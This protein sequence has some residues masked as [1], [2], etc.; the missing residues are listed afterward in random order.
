VLE[1]IGM[2][3]ART[4]FSSIVTNTSAMGITYV[5][6]SRGVPKAVLLGVD[7]YRGMEATIEE[8]SDPEAY[9]LLKAGTD[10]IEQ[11]RTKSVEEIFGEAIIW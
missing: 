1:A 7:E 2:G 9:K 3:D 10:D 11:G 4:N 6:H 8:M 5:I